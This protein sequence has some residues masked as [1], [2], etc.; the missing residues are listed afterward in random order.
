MIRAL[1]VTTGLG[2][3]CAGLYALIATFGAWSTLGLH[4][5]GG[6]ALALQHVVLRRTS[7]SPGE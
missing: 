4:C 5:I 2:L 7:C 1:T 6:L 3:Q